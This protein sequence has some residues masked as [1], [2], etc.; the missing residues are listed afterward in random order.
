MYFFF[1]PSLY[2]GCNFSWLLRL[3]DELVSVTHWLSH[4]YWQC[5]FHMHL[6]EVLFKGMF[7]PE[8]ALCHW[9]FVQ[10]NMCSTKWQ[11]IVQM[12]FSTMAILGSEE[13][14]H[15]K[16]RCLL[17]EG[18]VVLWHLFWIA[19]GPHFFQQNAYFSIHK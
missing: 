2:F 10:K 1:T 9:W 5:C 18:R 7:K 6:F 13:S 3:R 16:E 15:K 11:K 14:R 8:V 17:W 4:L 19:R 12:N